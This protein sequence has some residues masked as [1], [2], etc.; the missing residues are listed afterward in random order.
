M[1]RCVWEQQLL[2]DRQDAKASDQEL[3]EIEKAYWYRRLVNADYY[4]YVSKI[5]F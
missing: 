5:I 4:K 2:E 3:E 1:K